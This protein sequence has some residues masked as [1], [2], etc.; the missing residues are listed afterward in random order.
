MK[1]KKKPHRTMTDKLMTHNDLQNG[2]CE[3]NSKSFE[4]CSSTQQNVDWD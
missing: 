3:T 1:A 2:Q 4:I